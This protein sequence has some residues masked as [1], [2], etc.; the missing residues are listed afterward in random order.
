MQLWRE[1]S[2]VVRLH[3]EPDVLELPID[4]PV[5]GVDLGERLSCCLRP[6]GG[7]IVSL[8]VYQLIESS[9]DSRSESESHNL[10]E[11]NSNRFSRRC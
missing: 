1:L 4:Q 3:E 9:G 10:L 11:S 5:Q 8:L 7:E 2:R 6:E